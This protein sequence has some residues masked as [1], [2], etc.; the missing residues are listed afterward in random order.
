MSPD[1]RAW[2]REQVSAGGYN[3]ASQYICT[4]I[5]RDRQQVS[6]LDRLRGVLH[7]EEAVDVPRRDEIDARCRRQDAEAWEAVFRHIL[8]LKRAARGSD[9]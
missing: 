9:S 3:S 6:M 5:R 1:L 8:R 7:Y 4:L 2:V